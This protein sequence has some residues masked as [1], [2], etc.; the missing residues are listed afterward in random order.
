MLSNFPL[1]FTNTTANSKAVDHASTVNVFN[2]HWLAVWIAPNFYFT[3]RGSI[4]LSLRWVSVKRG[5]GIVASAGVGFYLFSKECCFR[6]RV[7]VSVKPN[8]NLNP[9]TAF[10]KKKKI[11]PDPGPGPGPA[12][13][14][15]PKIDGR[16]NIDFEGNF[17][18]KKKIRLKSFKNATIFR[19]KRRIMK[20][21]YIQKFMVLVS[22]S[23]DEAKIPS[24]FFG[25]LKAS[26]RWTLK[27][28]FIF[29]NIKSNELSLV[30]L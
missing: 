23:I 26:R 27:K 17:E 4:A 25:G 28:L 7:T 19:Y 1:V 14:W 2:C 13:Y 24:T 30:F 18:N 21:F 8:P 5:A 12:F 11:N 16:G 20:F 6:V 29:E 3:D 15:H 9:T 10:L 22:V